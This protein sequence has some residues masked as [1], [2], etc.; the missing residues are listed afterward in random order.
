[1]S[2]PDARGRVARLLPI[3]EWLPSYRRPDLVAD[4][5]AGATVGVLVIPQAMAYA[6]LAGVPPIA[7]LYAAMVS[8]VVYAVFGTSR[9]ISVG[10]VAIDSLLT[11]AA[12]APLADGDPGRYVALTSLLTVMIGVLQVGAGLAKLGALVNLLS[13]PVIAGFTSAAA[14]TIGLTQVRDLLG[15]D[16][17]GSSTTFVEGLSSVIP[18]L[19]SID[20][21]T[22]VLG[23]LSLAAL[24]AL[25]RWAPRLPGPLLL[26]GVATVLVVLLDLPVRQIGEIPSG[27]PLPRLP[28]SPWADVSALLPSAAAIALISYMES[29]STGS[30]FARKTRTRIEPDRELVAVGLANGGAGLMQGLPVAGGFSRGAVNYNAGAR[31]PMSGV[32]ASVLVAISLLL[33]TPVLALIPKAVLAAII[34]AAVA[35]LVDVRGARAVGRVRRSDLVALLAT[36]AAT[37]VLGPTWGLA[38]GVGVSFALFLRHLNRPHMPELGYCPEEKMFRNVSRHP[39]TTHPEVLVVRIDAP[40]SFVGARAISEDLAGRLRDREG[41]RFLVI[42]A[43][44]VNAADFT[45]VEMLGQLV[46]DLDGTGVQVHLGGLRGPVRD[47]LE[48]TEWFRALVAAGRVHGTVVESVRELPVSS[49]PAGWLDETTRAGR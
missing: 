35:T 27:I 34:L 17:S 15:L 23:V 30:A 10:P 37:L 21:T 45:G 28:D 32:V 36:A 11:A 22:A 6:A 1:M 19:D 12:V 46:E 8:L 4:L 20:V 48:R 2:G 7:G 40:L 16:L 43:T 49:R 31:T 33:L 29:I 47:V 24:V 26:V 18:S 13:V 3:A 5:R 14:L 38:L 42:D 39:A 25:K 44:A 9:F 41:T